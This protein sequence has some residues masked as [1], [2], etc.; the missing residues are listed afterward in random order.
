MQGHELVGMID[1][2]SIGGPFAQVGRDNARLLA[3]LRQTHVPHAPE[4]PH[5]PKLQISM[6]RLQ[7]L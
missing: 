3:Q 5:V 7:V 1:Q 2:G 4:A 6:L